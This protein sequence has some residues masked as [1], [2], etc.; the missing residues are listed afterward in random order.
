MVSSLGA[1]G[2]FSEILSTMWVEE[3]FYNLT[4]RALY[5]EHKRQ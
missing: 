4:D 2:I 3:A 1:V 5:R